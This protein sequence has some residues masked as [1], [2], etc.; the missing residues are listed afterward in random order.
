MDGQYILRY[1][2]T[3]HDERVSRSNMGP[4]FGGARPRVSFKTQKPNKK[5]KRNFGLANLDED[6]PMTMN[7]NNNTK[8]VIIRERGYRDGCRGRN[9]PLPSR[10]FQAGQFIG[11]RIRTNLLGDSDW[12]RILVNIISALYDAY[13]G[14]Y[15]TI[16]LSPFYICR[17]HMVT[18][19]RRTIS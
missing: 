13:R 12:Y 15:K 19:M 5:I 11:P 10:H 2:I 17:Y 9:S 7:S 4:H 3:V 16:K 14:F 8:Q 1:L 18:N 6:I